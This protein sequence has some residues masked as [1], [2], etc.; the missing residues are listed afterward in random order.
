MSFAIKLKI[1]N[2]RGIYLKFRNGWNGKA[3]IGWNDYSLNAFQ[4]IFDELITSKRGKK[5]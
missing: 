3:I 2:V 5:L 4:K 1:V